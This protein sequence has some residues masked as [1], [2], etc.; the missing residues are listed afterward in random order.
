MTPVQAA[1]VIGCTPHHVRWMITS[2]RISAKK[3]V[4]QVNLVGYESW[5]YDIEPSEV[6]MAR[7]LW[8]ATPPEKRRGRKAK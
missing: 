4:T 3:M 8:E 6:E 5:Q 2:G 1:R 7:Q